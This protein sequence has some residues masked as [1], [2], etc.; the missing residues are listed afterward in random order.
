[1]AWWG[2][3]TTHVPCNLLLVL[4]LRP[5]CRH[6]PMSTACDFDGICQTNWFSNLYYKER[7]QLKTFLTQ[8]GPALPLMPDPPVRLR[9]DQKGGTTIEIAIR[10]VFLPKTNYFSHPP[11]LYPPLV[12]VGPTRVW[13]R[14]YPHPTYPSGP[15]ACV[16]ASAVTPQVFI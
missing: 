11:H 2:D 9:D 15:P 8:F 3:A 16:S 5:L 1:M 10:K 13:T 7:R 4:P 12:P 14:V 6:L